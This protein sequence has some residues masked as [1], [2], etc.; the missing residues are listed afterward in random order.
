WR[1]DVQAQTVL[2][3][4]TPIDGGSRPETCSLQCSWSE[5]SRTEHPSPGAEWLRWEKTTVCDGRVR[6]GNPF[7]DRDGSLFK[8]MD[9]SKGCFNEGCT[10]S[11][12]LMAPERGSSPR[13]PF[14]SRVLP[15]RFTYFAP[16]GQ[17]S[18]QEV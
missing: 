3:V 9:F 13:H 18:C 17:R 2:A 15:L 5:L 8:A 12:F 4:Q 7:P 1:P 6:E 14:S 11:S 16:A 10:H